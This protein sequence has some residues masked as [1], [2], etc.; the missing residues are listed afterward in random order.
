MDTVAPRM[1]SVLFVRMYRR[2]QLRMPETVLRRRELRAGKG[3]MLRA[4]RDHNARRVRRLLSDHN[5]HNDQRLW[6]L[7]LGL[8][9][10]ECLG[11]G[12]L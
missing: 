10:R 2:C 3:E 8:R 7:Y 4:R 9:A 6:V 5:Q 12:K 11:F 1:A